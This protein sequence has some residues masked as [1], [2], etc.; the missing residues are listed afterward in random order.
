M[1]AR[2]GPIRLPQ[3]LHACTPQPAPCHLPPAPSPSGAGPR[4]R[5]MNVPTSNATISG[6]PT[7]A[8]RDDLATCPRDDTRP[9]APCERC[10]TAAAAAA[11]ARLARSSRTSPPRGH[12]STRPLAAT[13]PQCRFTAL[14]RPLPPRS[15]ARAP[16]AQGLRRLPAPNNPL[17]RPSSMPVRVRSMQTRPRV[18]GVTRDLWLVPK[19][20]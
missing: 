7:L 14:P 6:W 2:R 18:H 9:A 20:T 4:V 15:S 12:T 10:H 16:L 11:H 8:A 19:P 1:R 5:R 13:P 17:L 3:R